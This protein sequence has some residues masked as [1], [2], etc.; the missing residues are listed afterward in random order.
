MISPRL[1]Y[2][3][4][5]S[6]VV[7]LVFAGVVSGA[8]VTTA[9]AGVRTGIAPPALE[10]ITVSGDTLSWA[11]LRNDRPLVMVF[12]ATWCRVCKKDW[13]K[14]QRIEAR[15]RDTR[16]APVW[17]AVAM[18]ND[19]SLVAKVALERGLPGTILD[20]RGEKN[21]KQLGIDF[22]PTVCILD[23]KGRVAYFGSPNLSRIDAL[24]KQFTRTGKDPTP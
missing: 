3:P 13:P 24:L 15:Y 18:E 22:V 10:W 6:I 9:V 11:A 12:W 4:L 14:L 23:S 2:V 7:A 16:N 17:A 20:D 5:S 19:A 8:T 21:G 1:K